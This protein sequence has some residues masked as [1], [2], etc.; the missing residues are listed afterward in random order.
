[1]GNY[2][3][4]GQ[5]PLGE[6]GSEQ[7]MTERRNTRQR[8]LVLDEVRSRCDHPTAEQVFDGV[9]KIDEHLSRATVYRNLHLLADEGVILS[10]KVPGGERFDLRTDEHAHVMCGRCGRV[11][12]VDIPVDPTLE[13]QATAA[14]RPHAENG[15]AWTV[16][17]HA[18]VF[19]GLC[20]ACAQKE[21]EQK[22]A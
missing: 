21:Q 16:F 15:Y 6:A 13:A 10:I 4:R 14:L 22:E 7:D 18:T 20:P 12:D 17:S 5:E 9:H 8:Q 3:Q 19:E 2:L 11:M 1:V